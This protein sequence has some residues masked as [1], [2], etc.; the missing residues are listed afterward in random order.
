MPYPSVESD[1]LEILKAYSS[2]SRLCTTGTCASKTQKELTDQLSHT[3]PSWSDCESCESSEQTWGSSPAPQ[4]V[5]QV[6]GHFTQQQT[7]VLSKEIPPNLS[8]GFFSPERKSCPKHLELPDFPILIN[9]KTQSCDA[10]SATAKSRFLP[11]SLWG[12]CVNTYACRDRFHVV[13]AS[14]R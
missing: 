12:S 6:L 7:P 13:K 2:C 4:G 3:S 9:I 1:Y 8:W 11:C 10:I 14:L 5:L